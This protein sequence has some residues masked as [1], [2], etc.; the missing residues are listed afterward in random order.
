MLT[1]GQYRFVLQST[2]DAV[3]CELELNFRLTPEPPARRATG[4]IVILDP[5]DDNSS[6]RVEGDQLALFHVCTL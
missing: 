1:N 4:T 3:Q 5:E 2:S 6:T